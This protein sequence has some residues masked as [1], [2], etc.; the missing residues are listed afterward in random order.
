MFITVAVAVEKFMRQVLE[1][2]LVLEEM[3]AVV[4]DKELLPLLLMELQIQVVV[5]AAHT[6][7]LQVLVV[8]E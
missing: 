7:E 3:V 8:Q 5:V 1:Q 6:M 4:L 2:L